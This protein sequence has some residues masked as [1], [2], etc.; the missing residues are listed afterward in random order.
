MKP[1]LLDLYCGGGG[2]ALGYAAAGWDVVGVD[3]IPQ[4][5]YPYPIV[6]VDAIEF[7]L[8]GGARGFD[9][10][11]ASPPC[12]GYS[13]HVKS[14]SSRYARTLG[15]DTPRLIA[16]TRWPLEASGLPYV[17]EN[18]VGARGELL[19]PLLLC[20]VAFGLPIARHRYF[21]T[22]WRQANGP[23]HPVCRGVA[24]QYAE[25]RNWEYRDMSVTGKGRHAGTSDRWREILNLPDGFRMTQQNFREALP[26]A[27]GEWMGRAL[28]ARVATEQTA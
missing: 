27:Y 10:I 25:W 18:V 21:E 19:S 8:D 2:S 17:I 26:P 1:R 13:P 22:S 15:R 20:G 9:A 12:Q 24:K 6:V 28:L 14:A 4:P 16:A 5:D 7:L 23:A 11:H 3:H